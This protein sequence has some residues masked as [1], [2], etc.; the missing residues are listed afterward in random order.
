[1]FNF[2]GTPPQG[3]DDLHLNT[4]YTLYDFP[5]ATT[6]DGISMNSLGVGPESTFLQALV[7]DGAISS[8]TWSLFYGLA[9][10]DAPSQMDGTAVFGGYDKAKIVDEKQNYTKK[11]DFNANCRT[12]MVVIV[13]RIDVG[14]VNGTEQNAYPSQMQMC[15]DPAF[16]IMSFVPEI[17]DTLKEKFGGTSVNTSVGQAAGGLL[18]NA[19]EAWVFLSHQDEL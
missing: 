4:S 11:H 6:H 10:E 7:K 16:Q 19:N 1:M 13:T 12:G 18:Y 9:G 15:L 5:L 8:K 3:A 17:V 14:F 2:T